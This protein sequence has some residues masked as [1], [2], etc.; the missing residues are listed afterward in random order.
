MH[1]RAEVARYPSAV[2]RENEVKTWLTVVGEGDT[3]DVEALEDFL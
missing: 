3:L 2:S 1:L